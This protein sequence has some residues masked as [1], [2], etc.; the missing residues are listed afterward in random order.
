MPTTTARR[1]AAA[2]AAPRCA[3]A[4]DMDLF[5][6]DSPQSLSAARA[7]CLHCPILP[8]CSR[9]EDSPDVTTLAGLTAIQR[10]ALACA[11]MLGTEPDFEQGRE[12][13]QPWWHAII[14]RLSRRHPDPVALAHG[15]AQEGVS[16]SP[17]TARL[18]LWWQGLPGALVRP[19]PGQGRTVWP[20]ILT[21]HLSTVYTLLE[22]GAAP[23]DVASYLGVS[24]SSLA[25]ALQQAETASTP[26][27]TSYAEAA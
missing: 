27:G 24:P 7:I 9:N 23:A 11:R 19:V 12:L 17:A 21:L 15:L 8:M 6:N 18:L 1:P 2:P 25:R 3:S 5:H 14:T 20:Q 26:D 4:A 16:C 10:R 13:M 22:R